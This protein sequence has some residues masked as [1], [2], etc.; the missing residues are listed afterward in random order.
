RG[1]GADPPIE[2]IVLADFGI[3]PFVRW[4]AEVPKVGFAQGF[5]I[6]EVQEV[7]FAPANPPTR[8]H[9]A[10]GIPATIVIAGE[11]YHT[12]IDIDPNG[13]WL[14]PMSLNNIRDKMRSFDLKRSGEA[15]RQA[16]YFR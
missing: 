13:L 16:K 2:F 10:V 9:H 5:V 11:I 1:P 6:R 12:R 7:L 15:R 8:G 3:F 14:A 4:K